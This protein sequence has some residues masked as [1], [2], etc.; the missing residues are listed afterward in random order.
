MV[1][2]KSLFTYSP[3]GNLD[4][5]GWVE[6]IQHHYRLDQVDLIEKA[7]ELTQQFSKG[8][9]TF[10]G[11]PCLEQG[12][13]IAELILQLKL[14]QAAVAAGMLTTVLSYAHVT[15][16]KISAHLNEEVLQL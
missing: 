2:K 1:E 9:T 10:Y 5:V 7:V 11:K 15:P 13:E 16:D 6:K 3:E 8:L 4:L 12:L 14:D